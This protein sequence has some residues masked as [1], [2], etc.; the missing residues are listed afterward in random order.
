MS[1]RVFPASNVEWPT[2]GEQTY[3]PAVPIYGQV[4]RNVYC[5][6][7]FFQANDRYM[8]AVDI[9]NWVMQNSNTAYEQGDAARAELAR[10]PGFL[11]LFLEFAKQFSLKQIIDSDGQFVALLPDVAVEPTAIALKADGTVG[12]AV[13]K[14]KPFTMKTFEIELA[15]G[16]TAVFYASGNA[17]Q[18]LVYRQEGD[19]FW[20]DLPADANSGS[21]VFTEI[22]CNDDGASTSII[23]LFV[24]T[25]DAPTDSVTVTIEQKATDP[26]CS[27][28][29][30]TPPP[31][32]GNGT[33]NATSCPVPEGDGKGFILYPSNRGSGAYCPK[34]T[35]GSTLAA[36]C[37]PDGSNLD[38]ARSND[39]SLC[40]PGRKF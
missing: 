22:P 7:L 31:T 30:P 12:T 29:N 8:S 10:I 32:P 28:P 38:K 16:Q 5:T 25:A 40:C 36:W 11:D 24:S 33:C 2:P 19:S 13:L 1:N 27:T 21:L 34:G 9:H 3:D 37:C 17:N 4:D 15:P 26:S 35:H 14:T 6:A 18:K 20:T 23:V 39:I